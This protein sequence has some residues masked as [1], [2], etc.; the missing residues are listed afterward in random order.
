LWCSDNT[1]VG[2]LMINSADAGREL[3]T[4]HQLVLYVIL[5]FAGFPD[6]PAEKLNV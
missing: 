5:E 4:I 6:N 3:L 1:F 2:L